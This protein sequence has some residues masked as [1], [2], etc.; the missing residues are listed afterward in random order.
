MR[1]G[2]LL[3]AHEGLC[4]YELVDLDGEADRDGTTAGAL[5]LTLVR[6]T[7]WLSRGPMASRPLPAGPEDPLEGA[8]MLEPLVLRY[9]VA[10]DPRD[11]L[12]PYDTCDQAFS[13]LRVVH[14]P[15]EGELPA[16]GSWLDLHGATVDALMPDDRPDAA[17]G[18]LVVRVHEAHGRPGELVVDGRTGT[19]IDLTGAELGSFD[20]RLAL[21]PHQIVTL[22]LDPPSR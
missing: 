20:G 7:G 4:E 6:A 8:Q 18:G 19:V 16:S 10:V 15:G 3:V 9:V 5:A 22:R 17:A 2:G 1:A 21:R 11:M 14:S 12:D 13:P